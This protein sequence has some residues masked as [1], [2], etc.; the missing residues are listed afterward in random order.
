MS[1]TKRI[2]KALYCAKSTMSI[3]SY[4]NVIYTMHTKQ[5]KFKF[6]YKNDK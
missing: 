5:N 3:D 2:N 6:I 1:I 4:N